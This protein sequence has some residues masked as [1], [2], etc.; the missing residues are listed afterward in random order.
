M[1]KYSNNQKIRI[2]DSAPWNLAEDWDQVYLTVDQMLKV[3]PDLCQSLFATAS[4]ITNAYERLDKPIQMICESTCINC[5][6]IC[7]IRASIWFD[8]KDLLYLY[9]G[10][11]RFP[12]HQIHKK[13]IR[14]DSGLT[15]KKIFGCCH[16]TSKGC[17]LPRQKRPFV[18]TWY[19]CPPQVEILNDHANHLKQ[20]VKPVIP[21]IKELRQKLEEDFIRIAMADI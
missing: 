15:E 11:S 4:E 21:I 10:L 13:E 19:F 9:F 20:I 12:E 7:C 17:G 16:L 5:R 6:D 2:L 1:D 3:K 18:C 14:S 8:F